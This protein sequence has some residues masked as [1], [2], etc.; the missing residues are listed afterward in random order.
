[1]MNADKMRLEDIKPGMFIRWDERHPCKHRGYSS[2]AGSSWESGISCNSVYDVESNGCIFNPRETALT[3]AAIAV[4]EYAQLC[5]GTCWVVTGEIVGRGQDNEP[6]LNP[7]TITVL[8]IVEA[9]EVERA[10]EIKRSYR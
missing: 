1:M 4:A 3:W 5:G 10:I 9:V 2:C 8:G 7:T 6:C